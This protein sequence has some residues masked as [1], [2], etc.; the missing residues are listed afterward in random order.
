M[1]HNRYKICVMQK[2]RKKFLSN[3]NTFRKIVLHKDI[4]NIC[5]MQNYQIDSLIWELLPP[6]LSHPGLPPTM[7]FQAGGCALLNT[8]HRQGISG[9]NIPSF[10]ASFQSPDMAEIENVVSVL[11]DIFQICQRLLP[12]ARSLLSGLPNEDILNRCGAFLQKAA[13]IIGMLQILQGQYQFEREFNHMV[14]NLVAILSSYR[15]KIQKLTTEG[16]RR[17]ECK[18]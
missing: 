4:P 3:E 16:Q 14:S 6:G 13:Q 10:F 9:G 11:T 17:F 18:K 15:H 1:F 7:Y 2:L 8:V 12:E 5:I